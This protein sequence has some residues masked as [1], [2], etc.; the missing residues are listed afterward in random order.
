MNKSIGHHLRIWAF[1]LL[2]SC[3]LPSMA[4]DMVKDGAQDGL[5]KTVSYDV[6]SFLDIRDKTLDSMIENE[7]I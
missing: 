2:A 3:T 5:M 4:Q 6:A 1:A 7:E